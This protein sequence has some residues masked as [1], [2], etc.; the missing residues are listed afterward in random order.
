MT[1]TKLE[2][3]WGG[4]GGANPAAQTNPGAGAVA[5]VGGKKRPTSTKP[6]LR[7]PG[8]DG[9]RGPHPLPHP[10]PKVFGGSPMHPM[11]DGGVVAQPRARDLVKEGLNEK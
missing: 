2:G 3:G 4:P 9:I 10:R 1:K 11:A 8:E 7:R 6:K 5:T